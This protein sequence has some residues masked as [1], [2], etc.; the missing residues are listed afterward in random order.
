MQTRCE[1][2]SDYA[3]VVRVVFAYLVR[4]LETPYCPRC[5]HL[6]LGSPHFIVRVHRVILFSKDNLV[7]T[8]SMEALVSPAGREDSKTYSLRR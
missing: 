5:L 1:I 8:F 3:A 7:D 6:L 4:F 2:A